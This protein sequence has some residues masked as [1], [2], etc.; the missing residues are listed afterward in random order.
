MLRPFAI[1]NPLSLILILIVAVVLIGDE[2]RG[3]V[4]A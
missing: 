1:I 3:S 2:N 4:M